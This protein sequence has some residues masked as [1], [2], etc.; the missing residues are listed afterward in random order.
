MKHA[1]QI[2]VTPFSH[3]DLSEAKL[4]PVQLLRQASSRFDDWLV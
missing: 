2:V 4:R 1:G 3:T